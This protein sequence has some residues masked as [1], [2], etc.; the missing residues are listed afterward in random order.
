MHKFILTPSQLQQLENY[1]DKRGFHDPV[2]KAEILDHFACKVE[3][4]MTARPQ[5][6]LNEA[7]QKAHSSFGATGFY[8]IQ[9]NLDKHLSIKYKEIFNTELKRRFT[10][11]PNIIVILLLSYCT[12]KA[13]VWAAVNGYKHILG[14]NDVNT[15]LFL[16]ML[17]SL[18]M[19]GRR[20]FWKFQKNYYLKT[21]VNA[22]MW[23]N[24]VLPGIIM[25]N[26]ATS[27]NGIQ[28]C[29]IINA[30]CAVYFF[31]FYPAA[32]TTYSAAEN[33]YE[34]FRKMTAV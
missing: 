25:S 33:D 26:E 22:M 4:I 34:E 28:I 6:S 19:P 2:I 12:F 16:I 5:L 15:F 23:M 24:P 17:V 13:Y 29:A 31:A 3:E 14:Q 1:I 9:A 11:V 20:S 27:S 30:A 8:P 7:I 21:A 10:S 18:Y 32:Y